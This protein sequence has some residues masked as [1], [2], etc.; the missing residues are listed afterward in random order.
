MTD[1]FGSAVLLTCAASVQNILFQ[2][3][4]ITWGYSTANFFPIFFLLFL[5]ENAD[6]LRNTLFTSFIGRSCCDI[7]LRGAGCEF[8]GRPIC[9]L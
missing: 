1:C 5:H 3:A 9:L 6:D 8:N 2:H 7:C 4:G